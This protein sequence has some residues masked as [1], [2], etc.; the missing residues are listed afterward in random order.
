MGLVHV[1]LLLLL[2]LF[3]VLF[4]ILLIVRLF[5]IIHAVLSSFCKMKKGEI[6]IRFVTHVSVCVCVCVCVCV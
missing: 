1:L 3:V 2:T 6:V 4:L 5:N